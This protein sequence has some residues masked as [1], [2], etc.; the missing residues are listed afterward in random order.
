MFKNL[1]NE[2]TYS[3]I[4]QSHI[5]I[6]K[7]KINK[8]KTNIDI[9]YILSLLSKSY[10]IIDNYRENITNILKLVNNYDI[11]VYILQ[12]LFINI[13]YSCHINNINSSIINIQSDVEMI[14]SSYNK[15]FEDIDK[16]FKLAEDFLR[17]NNLSKLDDN[18]LKPIINYLLESSYISDEI[19]LE[20]NIL[21]LHLMIIQIEKIVHN[22][23]TILL[24]S[25]E[26][27][28]H[29][30]NKL[31]YDIKLFDEFKKYNDNFILTTYNKI[32]LINPIYKDIN[33]N[34]LSLISKNL[35]YYWLD[36][37][38]KINNKFLNK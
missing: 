2:S 31:E 10:P 11:H 30:E 36:F 16:E 28:E 27:P 5:D 32:K 23:M 6:N 24:E 12:P 18:E 19:T 9:N 8:L 14:F 22:D 1:T 4:L 37:V 34:I 29:I 3:T 26:I 33:I 38:S 21:K 35:I 7:T 13:L 20:D 15:L 25:F 17:Y